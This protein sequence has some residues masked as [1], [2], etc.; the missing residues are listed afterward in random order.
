MAV[1]L[2][3]AEYVA[4]FFAMHVF[5][6]FRQLLRDTYSGSSLHG[7]SLITA[8]LDNWPAILFIIEGPSTLIMFRDVITTPCHR[9]DLLVP[10]PCPNFMHA[11]LMFYVLEF[12][13]SSAVFASL[14]SLGRSKTKS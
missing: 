2:M 11:G 3:E 4:C 13:I 7:T 12:W 9:C 6:W 8:L 1:S 10:F 14:F 5:V